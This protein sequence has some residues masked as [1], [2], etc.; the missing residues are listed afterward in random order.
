MATMWAEM[1]VSMIRWLCFEH[2]AETVK[3]SI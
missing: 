1:S 3:I 2:I